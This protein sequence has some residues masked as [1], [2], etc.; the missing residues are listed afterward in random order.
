ME[1]KVLNVYKVSSSHDVN[2]D[3]FE[4]G[5]LEHAN[6]YELSDEVKAT[7]WKDAIQKYFNEFLC[8]DFDIKHSY[9]DEEN[10]TL[11]YSNLVDND[12]IEVSPRQKDLWKEG[13]LKLYSNNTLVTVEQITKVKLV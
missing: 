9:I 11:Q 2:V 10:N 5:E 13:K 7:D 12:N 8:F 6:Y 4:Q 1:A 3:D